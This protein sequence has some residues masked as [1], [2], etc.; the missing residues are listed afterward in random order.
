MSSVS[1]FVLSG[2][3]SCFF[4]ESSSSAFPFY[5]TFSVSVNLGEKV[6]YCGLEGLFLC[7]SIAV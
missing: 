2:D 6:N 7:G 5:L 4:I 3:F 1:F